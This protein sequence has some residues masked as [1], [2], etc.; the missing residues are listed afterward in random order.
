MTGLRHSSSSTVIP[1]NPVPDLP[2]PRQT[3]ICYRGTAGMTKGTASLSVM[4][5]GCYRASRVLSLTT[6]LPLDYGK[7]DSRLKLAGMK[8][9]WNYIQS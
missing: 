6:R 1:A 9:N 7:M 2:V 3:G 4:P 8:G 5:D